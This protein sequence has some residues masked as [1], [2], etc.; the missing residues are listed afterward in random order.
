MFGVAVCCIAAGCRPSYRLKAAFVCLVAVLR[1][2]SAI[3]Q[4]PQSVLLGF[5]SHSS[6]QER[7]IEQRFM[8]VPTAANAK[9][10]LRTLT[11]E[12]HMAGSLADRRTAEFV[13][14]QFRSFGLKAEIEEFHVT[15]SEPEH[16]A[17]E[18]TG[19]SHFYGPSPEYVDN[20]P[21]S[22]DPRTTPGFNAF[23][24]S[25]DVA[26]DV[27]YV[28]YGS[29]A[30]YQLLRDR[31]I[32]VEGK[33]AVARY[34]QVYRGVKALL[35]EQHRAA[36]LI[37]YSDPQDDGYHQGDVYPAGPW[38]PD[39]GIQRGSVLYDFIYPGVTA[40]N[41]NVPHIP[42]MPISAADARRILQMLGGLAAPPEWQGA[43]PF[44]YH[45]GPGPAHLRVDVR[46]RTVLR[47]VWNVV[48][49]IQ[50]SAPEQQ[51]EIVLVGNH[52]DA[53]V[54][55]AV[56]PGSGTTALVEMARGLG[57]LMKGGWHPRRSIWICSWDAEEPDE[58]GSTAWADKHAN[59]LRQN[60]V[61]YLNVDSAVAGKTFGGAASPSLKEFMLQAAADVP[62]PAGGS[63]LER[64]NERRRDELVRTLPA[65]SVPDQQGWAG[66][67]SDQ[68]IPFGNLG[69]GTDYVT[70][71]NHLGIP[72]SDFGF[73][74]S[75][76]VYHSIFDN[77]RWMEQFGDPSFAYHVAASRFLGL[78]VLRL[79]DA[80]L[81]PL[82][83]QRYGLEIE[84]FLNAVH[85]K[86]VLLDQ[87]NR[88]D[89]QPALEAMRAFS[90]SARLL[91][92]HM[93]SKLAQ[94]DSLPN[95][96]RI[97]LDLASAERALLL[98]DGL[99]GRPWYKHSIFAPAFFSGYKAAVLP[100]VLESADAGHWQQAQAQLQALTAAVNRAAATIRAADSAVNSP[101]D[102]PARAQP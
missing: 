96:G 72:S 18:L 4:A 1:V 41:S 73:E 66:L 92:Q 102:S 43:L 100:G 9:E 52:R 20:D 46:M 85:E 69:G 54:Y 29:A 26:G 56:D 5:R 31:G 23:S 3:A 17:F 6:Q 21:A 63:L 93:E 38:R 101:S 49:R 11:A 30:D 57:F 83:Y 47:A 89:F 90:D 37:I 70:F 40:D 59:E 35:A 8:E 91:K 76:G 95:P 60:A 67:A 97:D 64:V 61:A 98:E 7:L 48:A 44:T 62:D 82:N 34:G 77:Y 14:Q 28:N 81:L 80:D 71:F 13:L 19:P 79:S 24:A 2:P 45:V 53:W 55:G 32:V 86:L 75:Y 51:Q 99:P 16:V 68:D 25:G 12:P 84:K 74:D 94:D 50:A 27:V 33:I 88:L 65:G 87:G 15:V 42:V 22:K 78:E 10:T 36:A 58:L 39:S